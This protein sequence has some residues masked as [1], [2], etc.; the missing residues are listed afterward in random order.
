MLKIHAAWFKSI[1]K[2]YTTKIPRIFQLSLGF[3]TFLQVNGGVQWNGRMCYTF[4]P[5]CAK[6]SVLDVC[7]SQS[8][9]GSEVWV[10]KYSYQL[11]ALAGWY[12][13]VD[14][15]LSWAIIV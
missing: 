3:K 14:H 10:K 5:F 9:N 15:G 4:G 12:M 1:S 11:G 6:S 7:P 13:I 2:I 8:E